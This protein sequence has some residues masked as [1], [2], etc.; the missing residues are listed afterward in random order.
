MSRMT[1]SLKAEK[2]GKRAKASKPAKR[3]ETATIISIA[4]R[5]DDAPTEDL[6]A[7]RLL[8]HEKYAWLL[9]SLLQ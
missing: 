7:Q 4:P 8:T 6:L 2:S 5:A 3:S 1:T 9:R